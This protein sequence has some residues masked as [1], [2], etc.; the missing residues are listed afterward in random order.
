MDKQ[1]K[2]INEMS[3]LAIVDNWDKVDLSEWNYII[4]WDEFD[5]SEWN[6]K[7]KGITKDIS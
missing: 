2:A 7:N 5:L 1:P 3:E 4:D 6:N